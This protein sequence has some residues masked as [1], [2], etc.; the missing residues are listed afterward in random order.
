ME[1]FVTHQQL[2]INIP[3]NEPTTVVV[4]KRINCVISYAGKL[5]KIQLVLCLYF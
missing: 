3:G 1:C 5:M 4:E 2:V